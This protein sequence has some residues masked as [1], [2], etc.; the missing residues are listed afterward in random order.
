MIVLTSVIPL[1]QEKYHDFSDKQKDEKAKSY[2]KWLA[3]KKSAEQKKI[4]E[5][6]KEQ[7]KQRIMEE[8]K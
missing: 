3:K 4:D 8:D 6:R 7:E 5:Q 2:E 1:K